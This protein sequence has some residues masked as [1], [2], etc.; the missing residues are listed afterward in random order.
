[1]NRIYIFLFIYVYLF[2]F[3]KTFFSGKLNQQQMFHNFYICSSLLSTILDY[4]VN[5]NP[6]SSN[7]KVSNKAF[8]TKL[9]NPCYL[10]DE[11]ILESVDTQSINLRTPLSQMIAEISEANET[12]EAI[13]KAVS[14]FFFTIVFFVILYVKYRARKKLYTI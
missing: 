12:A 10:T 14:L 9:S 13:L 11:N 3:M 7:T 6:I 1:M 2:I 4:P 8:A 5:S